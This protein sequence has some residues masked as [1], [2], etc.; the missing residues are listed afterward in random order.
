MSISNFINILKLKTTQMTIKLR[1]NEQIFHE[2]KYSQ[3]FKSIYVV[4]N[5]AHRHYAEPQ[6]TFISVQFENS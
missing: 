2:M 3:Q 5:E 4:M 6:N 1:M